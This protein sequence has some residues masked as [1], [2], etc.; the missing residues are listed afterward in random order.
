MDK[1]NP[2][3]MNAVVILILSE[4]LLIMYGY[5]SAGIEETTSHHK[6]DPPQLSLDRNFC[7]K[8]LPQFI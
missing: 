2:Q 5:V 4:I 7:L 8:R 3:I 1:P 6:H